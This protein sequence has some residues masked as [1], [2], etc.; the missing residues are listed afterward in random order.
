[1]SAIMGIFFAFKQKKSPDCAECRRGN[2]TKAGGF[3][4]LQCA[5]TAIQHALA[6]LLTLLAQLLAC[7]AV[8]EQLQIV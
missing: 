8:A 5:G 3:K 7:G 6:L 2:N 1:M 4:Y